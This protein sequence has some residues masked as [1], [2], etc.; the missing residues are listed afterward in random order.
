[1]STTTQSHILIRVES[2]L[3][4]DKDGSPFLSQKTTLKVTVSDYYE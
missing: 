1:M 4:L 3:L 2:E